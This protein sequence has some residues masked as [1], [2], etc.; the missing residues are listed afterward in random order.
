MK[1][2]PYTFLVIVLITS[3]LSFIPMPEVH[4]LPA[5]GPSISNDGAGNTVVTF[6]STTACTW[7]I[8][9]AVTTVTKILVVG[10]GGGGGGA[11]SKNSPW[12]SPGGGGGGGGVYYVNTGVNVSSNRSINVT[13]GAGGSGGAK[14]CDT[15]AAGTTYC[16]DAGK[17]IYAT[18]GGIGGTSTLT[19]V[20]VSYAAT[21]G[22]GGG[23]GWTTCSN[24]S[25]TC[26]GAGGSS[27]GAKLNTG[28]FTT[29][30]GGN[31]NEDGSGGGGGASA[32]GLNGTDNNSNGN[33]GGDGG[34]GYAVSITGT[35]QSYGAGGGGGVAAIGAG[36]NFIGGTGGDTGGGHGGQN[37]YG[38][39]YDKNPS[40]YG[41][42]GGGG[43]NWNTL[44]KASPG[45]WGYN[46]VVIL[47]YA[48][49]IL[50]TPSAP[51]ISSI[52]G[53]AT[54]L[55]ATFTPDVNATS[56]TAKVYLASDGTTQV[57]SD[58]TGYTSGTAITGLTTGTGY[59]VR[60]LALGDGTN[61][62][63]SSAG[64]LSSSFTPEMF[65]QSISSPIL[66]SIS[67][68]YPFSQSPLA[69]SSV[70]GGSGSGALTV[71]S[72]VDVTSSIGCAWD[73]TTLSANSAGVCRLTVTKA[74]DDNYN[75]ATSTAEFTFIAG[76]VATPSIDVS[77][78]DETAA[79]NSTATFTVSASTGDG[80]TLSY[81]WQK[82]VNS[83]S[84]WEAITEGS[85]FT[86][87]SYT[88]PT[89]AV[90]DSGNKFR[91]VVTNSNHGNTASAPASN[92]ATLTVN[93]ASQTITF[94][95]LTSKTNGDSS[96]SI[97]AS[98]SS[99]LTV[100][101]T[102]SNAAVCT[103]SDTTVTIASGG[104]CTV[105]ANNS[106][107]GNYLAATQESQSFSIAALAL[108]DPTAPTLGAVL[109]SATSIAA[110]F[111][112]V[113]HAS[114]HTA[115]VYLASDGTTQVGGDIT[116]YISE[117]AITGLTTGT[118]YKV[119]ITAIGDGTNYANSGASSPSASYTPVKATQ[120]TLSIAATT[121]TS[122]FNGSSYS[123]TP[124]L[125]TSGGSG[126]GIVTYEIVNGGTASTCV[127]SSNAASATLSATTF[128][129]CLIRATKP[130]NV[131]YELALSSSDLT[132]TFS[133]ATQIISFGSL[134]S[135]IFGNANFY[136]SATSSS[137][138][139]IAFTS[140]SDTNCTISGSTVSI[141]AVGTCTIYANQEGNVN[142]LAATQVSQ[143]FAISKASQGTLTIAAST[144]TSA[145]NGSSYSASPSLSTSGGSGDGG[146][147]YSISGGTASTCALSSSAA[148][149]TLSATTIGT[150]LI[151]AT[152]AA[153]GDYESVISSSD[154]TFTFSKATQSITFG[155]LS[156]KTFGDDSFS[157]SAAASS[158]L[159]VVFTSSN[160]AVCTISGTTVTIASGGG[161]TIYADQSG[162]A[163][164]SAATR[165]T[166]AFAISKA[167]QSITFG[168]LSGKTFGDVSFSISA[169]ASS[170][171]T[172]VFTSSNNAICA[173]AGTIVTIASGGT[174]TIYADQSGDANYSAAT[175]VTQAFVIAALALSAPASPTLSEVAGS[176]TSITVT[177]TGITNAS[178]Y[179]AR[180][181]LASNG[182][183]LVG[184]ARTNFAIGDPITGLTAGVAYK[185]TI[186][187]LGDGTTYANSSASSLSASFTP[188]KIL[189]TSTWTT[190]PSA[191]SNYRST[192]TLSVTT[193]HE[194]TVNFKDG[195]TSIT[196]CGAQP[197]SAGVATCSWL[198]SGLGSRSITAVLT[199][200]NSNY[201]ISTSSAS[202]VT[203]ANGSAGSTL[204]AFAFDVVLAKIIYLQSNSITAVMSQPGK[205]TFTVDGLAIPGCT[206]V[207]STPTV[208]G[209][210]SSVCKYR[211][212]KL[213]SIS[214]TVTVTP[215][216]AGYAV[217]SRKLSASVSPK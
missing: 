58:I 77:P 55:A 125:S 53:S 99:S 209:G 68:A 167:S 18:A 39:E 202:V 114:S 45:A 100:T 159:T 97:S 144:T 214:I 164:Y 197:T 203:V 158:S 80:G 199:P 20:S 126:D 146:V 176:A 21:Y 30:I 75:S 134:S 147:T 212:T 66:S 185:V 26:S 104:I 52:D 178:S 152:K 27:P 154:L 187:A 84:S 57:G 174:C 145:F 36:N 196:G 132:F 213:S 136:L 96:F 120:T 72:V 110:T 69:V 63:S 193:S 64:T 85:G 49:P 106:G 102:S 14:G 46:G 140:S 180:A 88:T 143:S 44:A 95:A 192:V 166:Q 111:S 183:T 78:T 61:Y 74:A 8:P 28:T 171:L 41:A 129:T 37:N 105:Y 25:T 5:C 186:T 181:Y 156:G 195:A 12:G 128:G 32:V 48:T 76:S 101:F 54:S 17:N 206:A 34:D 65:S 23:A 148:N 215:T 87:N 73:G 191:A 3:A 139:T 15:Y 123:A 40:F 107:N 19:L 157:I 205:A 201:A 59:K 67:K 142:Y 16:S 29:K 173:I 2:T 81:M 200:T 116:S 62:A 170:S 189:T 122:A 13:V 113:A 216:N 177:F 153:N 207:K 117:A 137:S 149:A 138:L 172:V 151:R 79:Y 169:A 127:L 119:T 175:R 130:A 98:A 93:K 162:D 194:G 6:T 42:G 118:A 109:A 135:K 31:S 60:L 190:A 112:P 82:S 90:A 115:K 33:N 165:A 83:G 9:S 94:G 1:K 210:N 56:Y 161:C 141:R 10:G 217:A 204:T 4:A 188:I 92:V 211:P 103:V 51:T 198:V 168:S 121:L 155:S 7:T 71:S 163:N 208:G 22:N 38:S 184:S 91:A 131:N 133:K 89:L 70:T 160:N 24:V 150:C 47:S 35:S 182:T 50:V 43:G 108:S 124:S 11:T 179:T 86:S